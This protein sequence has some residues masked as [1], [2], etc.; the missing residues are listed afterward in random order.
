M[1]DR[2]DKSYFPSAADLAEE[3]DEGILTVGALLAKLAEFPKDALV[4]TEGCDCVGRAM[5]ASMQDGSAV[6]WRHK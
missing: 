1:S 3:K 5:D 4:L 2:L 6:I